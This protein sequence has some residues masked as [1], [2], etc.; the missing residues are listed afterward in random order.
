[1][2]P[3]SHR[4]RSVLGSRMAG[5]RPLGLMARYSG[6]LTSENGVGITS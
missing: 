3:D 4:V 1:M 6:F 5:R 2:A